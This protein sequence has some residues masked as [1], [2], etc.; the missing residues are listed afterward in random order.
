MTPKEIHKLVLDVG[1]DH[2]GTFSGAYRG[3]V[4]LQQVPD[5]I[6]QCLYYLQQAARME[7][8]LEI[9]A[10]S[11]GLTYLVSK[12]FHLKIIV[13]VDNNAHTK[14]KWRNSVLKNIKYM[15]VIGD[16][17]SPQIVDTIKRMNYQFDLVV[18]DADHRYVGVKKDIDNYKQFCRGIMFI[19]DTVACKGVKK[20][21]EE[22]KQDGDFDFM[23]ELVSSTSPKCGIG[24]FSSVNCFK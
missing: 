24:I 9:G 11:G 19:H 1:S 20:A 13:L 2:L 21:F 6:A 4:N 15:Q 14:S 5:E 18:I 7:N 23:S 3:G 8:Y 16:S 10:A 12:I 17:Q 22:F